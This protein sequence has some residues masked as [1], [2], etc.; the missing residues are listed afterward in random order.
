MWIFENGL[1]LSMN[2]M[3][4]N[5]KVKPLHAPN[6]MPSFQV[7]LEAETNIRYFYNHH[8]SKFAPLI[9]TFMSDT[10][11]DFIVIKDEKTLGDSGVEFMEM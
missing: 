2:G 3:T 1:E 6:D 10:R 5:T 11:H 8:S 4:G 7:E 9:E